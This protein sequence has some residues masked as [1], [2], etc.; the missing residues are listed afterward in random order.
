MCVCARASE[1]ACEC[2]CACVRACAGGRADVCGR[3]CACACARACGC[4]REQDRPDAYESGCAGS[5]VSG[6]GGGSARAAETRCDAPVCEEVDGDLEDEERA[7]AEVDLVEHAAQIRQLA[8]FVVHLGVELR[9][10]DV[11]GEVL[12]GG[13]GGLGVGRG[14]VSFKVCTN[15]LDGDDK[16]LWQTSFRHHRKYED[17]QDRLAGGRVENVSNCLLHL[18][19][20]SP[21][22]CIF[23]CLFCKILDILAH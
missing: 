11:G 16:C 15:E 20:A 14:P 17:C 5:G 10:H 2:L 12:L 13:S 1:R 21:G 4:E 8:V 22:E 19:E 18:V 9:R 6:R 3:A 23:P 7:E